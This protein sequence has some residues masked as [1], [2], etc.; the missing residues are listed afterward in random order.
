[1]AVAILLPDPSPGRSLHIQD[2]YRGG[3]YT[4]REEKPLKKSQHRHGRM[5][6]K[7][8]QMQNTTNERRTV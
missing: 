4:L 2:P 1:M 3:L 7:M 5:L 6:A 8:L